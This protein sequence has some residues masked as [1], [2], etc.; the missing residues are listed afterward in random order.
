MLPARSMQGTIRKTF[1]HFGR[2][3]LPLLQFESERDALFAAASMLGA[4]WGKGWIFSDIAY[5][6]QTI[7][8][9]IEHA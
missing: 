1:A 3:Q 5:V 9:N 8:T 4:E 6:V 7:T 2:S